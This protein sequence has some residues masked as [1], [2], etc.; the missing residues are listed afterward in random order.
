MS[1]EKYINIG[2]DQPRIPGS[3][4]VSEYT[5]TPL[6]GSQHPCDRIVVNLLPPEGSQNFVLD[7]TE[8]IIGQN[9]YV[10]FENDKLKIDPLGLVANTFGRRSGNYR[11][12]IAGYRSAIYRL[13]LDELADDG[14]T[15]TT[16]PFTTIEKAD[17]KNVILS[18]ARITEISSTRKEVRVEADNSTLQ[19]FADF[20]LNNRPGIIPNEV[21]WLYE[22]KSIDGGTVYFSTTSDMPD[23]DISNDHAF[24][25]EAE[26]FEHRIDRGYPEDWSMIERREADGK[27]PI[28]KVRPVSDNRLWP[29][30]LRFRNTTRPNE[31]T[32]V[33][34]SNWINHPITRKNNKGE[35]I[36]RDTVIFR[37]P[38]GLPDSFVVNS[39][40]EI[41]QEIMTAYQIPVNI[42]L[43]EDVIIEFGELRGPNLD[44]TV[45]ERT[46][47]DTILKS[48][49]DLVG[50]NNKVKNQI[51]NSV[52]SGSNSIEQNY[53]FRKFNNFIHFSSAEERLKNFK[54]KL[55]LIEHFASKSYAVSEGLTGKA[56]SA[57]TASEVFINNKTFYDKKAEN[58][59]SGFDNFEKYLFFTSHSTETV[60]NETYPSATWPKQTSEQDAGSYTLFSV[61]SSEATAWYNERLVSA[62]NYDA[63]NVSTLRNV[64]PTHIKSDPQND[65]YILFFDMIGQHFDNMFYDIKAL[66]EMH[67]RNEDVN[68][69]ISKDM[70]YD[71]AKSF[72]WTLQ[73]GF[74][75]SELWSTL[76]GT[77]ESG[78]YQASG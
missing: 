9:E 50:S 49:D 2:Y 7:S 4:K 11:I 31:T 68:V 13:E 63:D 54:Y 33:A 65:P 69:G 44:I 35:N 8:I 6:L 22:D 16:V 56:Q 14:D 1:L 17:T 74:D 32:I 57:A 77:D 42:D 60:D 41:L 78:V 66:E 48:F 45:N 67:E 26:Y 20:Q 19:S 10:V 73:S 25:S 76:L 23:Y 3:D 62:S 47:N 18:T 53:D 36:D 38:K 29:C 72:G 70:I 51:I 30:L 59:K 61:T 46:G 58:I 15:I 5:N 71:L 28:V 52:I 12:D 21:Y 27:T 37:L 39:N 34:T 75:T 40:I 55:T 24:S 64:V 43:K